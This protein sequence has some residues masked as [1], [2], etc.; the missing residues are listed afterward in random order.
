MGGFAF[1]EDFLVGY[2][3]AFPGSAPVAARP[4]E[5]QRLKLR[6]DFGIDERG[7]YR[8][9]ADSCIGVIGGMRFFGEAPLPLPSRSPLPGGARHPEG[10]FASQALPEDVTA[11]VRLAAS[12]SGA[13]TNDVL[14]RD[15]F[16]VLRDWSRMA[17]DEPGRRRLRILMPQN[18]RQRD[19]RAMPAANVMSF[20]FLTRRGNACNR[21]EE[22]LPSIHR[23]TELIRRYRLSLYFLGSIG[24][25]QSTG[26]FQWLMRRPF[27]F[28]TAVLT[29]LG[30]PTRRFVARLPRS[31]AGLVAGNLVLEHITGGP[32][33]RPRTKAAFS[34]FNQAKALS[35]SLKCDPHHYS[36]LDTR[37]LLGEY[38]ARLRLTGEQALGRR[39]SADRAPGQ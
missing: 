35:I 30:D 33:V 32:P 29:N 22:L 17:G 8:R 25:I 5:P 3:A 10:G 24:L 14:L 13:T 38:V 16:V 12:R 39:S 4:L 2:A 34:I 28:T 37:Q 19:D 26:G 9:L 15:L 36:L 11:G 23:E 21:P 6:Q 27:C 7:L 31:A 1:I 18:L 20:A